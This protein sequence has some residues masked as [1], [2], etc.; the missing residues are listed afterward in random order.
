MMCFIYPKGPQTR[1]V[2]PIN[3][4]DDD[5]DDDD[6]DNNNDDDD[7]D[8]VVVSKNYFVFRIIIVEAPLE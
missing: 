4:N 5:D 1:S 7:D 6:D 3:Y 2:G 8:N